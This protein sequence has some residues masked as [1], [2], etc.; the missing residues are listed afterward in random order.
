MFKYVALNNYLLADDLVFFLLS[1]LIIFVE[2]LGAA[3]FFFFAASGFPE[4]LLKLILGGE[5][6]SYITC[7]CSLDVVEFS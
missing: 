7:D 5:F 4:L 6:I 3:S 1:T 2:L